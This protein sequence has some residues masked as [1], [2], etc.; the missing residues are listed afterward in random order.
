MMGSL[1]ITE[2][3]GLQNGPQGQHCEKQKCVF[4]GELRMKL[5][6]Q[7]WYFYQLTNQ[8]SG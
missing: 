8:T 5:Q 3:M 7:N 1:W 2:H 6:N 4:Y